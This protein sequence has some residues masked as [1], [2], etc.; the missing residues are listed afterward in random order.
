MAN[1]YDELS[2]DQEHN[3]EW[4][5]FHNPKGLPLHKESSLEMARF[6]DECWE[7]NL[8]PDEVAEALNAGLTS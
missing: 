2:V 1:H 4:D 6:Y 5:P 7:L 3:P 8:N